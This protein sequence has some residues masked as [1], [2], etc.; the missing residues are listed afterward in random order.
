MSDLKISYDNGN[1]ERVTEAFSTIMDFTDFV[2][3]GSPDISMKGSNVEADF[4]E[5]PLHHKHFDTI[6]DLYAHCKEIMR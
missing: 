2:E 6:G 4:F 3:S 5:N 1:G